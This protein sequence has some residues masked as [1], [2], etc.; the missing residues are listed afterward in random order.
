MGSTAATPNSLRTSKIWVAS[1]VGAPCRTPDLGDD[2]HGVHLE[3][4]EGLDG[5]DA[6]LGGGVLEAQGEVDEGALGG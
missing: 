2:E 1:S 3:L 5:A 6:D 4:A